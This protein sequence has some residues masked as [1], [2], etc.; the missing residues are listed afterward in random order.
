MIGTTIIEIGYA[1]TRAGQ[2]FPW[3]WEASG[4]TNPEISIA[5][6]ASFT[7]QLKLRSQS[8]KRD[9]VIQSASGE[10]LNSRRQHTLSSRRTLLNIHRSIW[11]INGQGFSRMP[12][13]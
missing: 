8:P 9:P 3:N 12:R 10:R 5:T 6:S 7:A 2:A 1:T 4:N 13:V 11:R